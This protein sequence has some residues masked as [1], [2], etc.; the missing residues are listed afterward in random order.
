MSKLAAQTIIVTA[1]IAGAVYLAANGKDGWGWLIVLAV[2]IL[3]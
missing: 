3:A 1:C 2:L